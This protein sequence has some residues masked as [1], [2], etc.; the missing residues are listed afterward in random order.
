MNRGPRAL[1]LLSGAFLVCASCLA[2]PKRDLFFRFFCAA[3]PV[4]PTVSCIEKMACLDALSAGG[5]LSDEDIRVVR[6]A[7]TD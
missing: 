1:F 6:A 3:A 5:T 2:L 4:Y 7:K